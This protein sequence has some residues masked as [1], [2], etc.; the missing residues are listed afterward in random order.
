VVHVS[1]GLIQRRQG[2]WDD[3]ISSLEKA[4]KLDPADTVTI[5]SLAQCYFA[6]RR[7]AQSAAILVKP[8]ADHPELLEFGWAQ[9]YNQF[10]ADG[11]AEA[12]HAFARRAVPPERQ[13]M[14]IYLQSDLA[15]T[16]GDWKEFLRL[17][18]VQRYYDGNTDDAKWGQ[19]AF[20]AEAYAE[21]GDMDTARV[22]ASEALV[23]LDAERERQPDNSI[24]WSDL[25]L[26]HAL[27]GHRAEALDCAKKS[28]ELLP[29]SRDALD[30]P[31]NSLICATALA[32]LG[33]KDQ[34]IAEFKRL[35]GVPFGSNVYTLRTH[36]RPLQDD[37]RFRAL[38]DDPAN[39]APF[40]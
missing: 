35:F 9:A 6:T 11:S 10:A 23:Q 26:A 7:Y 15:F 5:S 4:L 8:A 1:L 37:P 38:L 33:E 22:R 21:T 3:A 17:R 12:I 32:Y 20:L 27:L 18:G 39:N 14:F 29:E 25:A 19:D 31:G 13:N 2:R 34:A 28:A 24:V 30:G 16:S 40:P 36:V